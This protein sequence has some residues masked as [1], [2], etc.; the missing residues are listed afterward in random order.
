MSN[1]LQNIG[2]TLGLIT[3]PALAYADGIES[4][5]WVPAGSTESNIRVGAS[6]PQKTRTQKKATALSTRC[7]PCAEIDTLKTRIKSLENRE[8][9]RQYDSVRQDLNSLSGVVDSMADYLNG[10]VKNPDSGL[11]DQVGNV[12]HLYQ[13]LLARFENY[14]KTRQTT[15]QMANDPAL[16]YMIPIFRR[17]LAQLGESKQRMTKAANKYTM[18]YANAATTEKTVSESRSL[19]QNEREQ[20]KINLANV[21]SDATLYSKVEKE[22]KAAQLRKEFQEKENEFARK[23]QNLAQRSERLPHL[24]RES[25]E[26][27]QDYT[28]LEKELPRRIQSNIFDKR[29]GSGNITMEVGVQYGRSEAGSSPV[30]RVSVQAAVCYQGKNVTFCAGAGVGKAGESTS[31][32]DLSTPETR[33]PNGEYTQASSQT[34]TQENGQRYQWDATARVAPA[35]LR[36]GRSKWT[37]TPGALAKVEFSR[38]RMTRDL[39][40]TTQL[41]RADQEVGN[42]VSASGSDTEYSTSASFV[43]GGAVDL[44]RNL[45]GKESTKSFCVRVGGGYNVH[46]EMPVFDV[47]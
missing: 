7:D 8:S 17:G 1:I 34:G 5:N 24:Y 33:T 39:R 10:T 2:F 29:N 35:D 16:E 40:R 47:G 42:P 44:C 31:V 11:A 18:A 21:A 20:L 23:E 38:D 12:I 26:A 28:D 6:Q 32:T 25:R 19:L 14:E 4:G 45:W 27:Q 3:A 43:P 41:Y 30:G 9:G 15:E 46:Q 36:V 37:L 13:T 22:A